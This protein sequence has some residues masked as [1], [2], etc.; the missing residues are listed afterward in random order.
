MISKV[1]LVTS[2][3][4]VALAKQTSFDFQA[5]EAMQSPNVKASSYDWGMFSLGVILGSTV[6]AG[7]NVGAQP[8]KYWQCIGQSS[9]LLESGYF[10]YF[11]IRTFI[12][13]R[14]IEYVTYVSVYITRFINSIHAGPCWNFG[15]REQPSEAEIEANTGLLAKHKL[16]TAFDS[17]L[18][19]EEQAKIDSGTNAV[20]DQLQ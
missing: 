13:E 16:G 17:N 19:P 3:V 4:A 6:E 11:F 8:Q 2:L 12:E 15:R 1:T 5:K 7:T 9:D 18:T 20:F 14:S 10:S